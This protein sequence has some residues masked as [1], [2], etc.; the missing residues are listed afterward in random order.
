MLIFTAVTTAAI[1]ALSQRSDDQLSDV[2]PSHRSYLLHHHRS[3]AHA[4]C[5][6]SKDKGAGI[7]YATIYQWL[8]R[9]ICLLPQRMMDDAGGRMDFVRECNA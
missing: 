7:N 5:V 4:D 9:V 2:L 6:I 3:T 8:F 1:H